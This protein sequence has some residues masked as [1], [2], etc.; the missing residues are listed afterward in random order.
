VTTIGLAGW[1][2]SLPKQ[3]RDYHEIAQLSGIP[4]E[5]IRDKFGIHQVY[6]AG[7]DEHASTL[8][9]SAAQN[10]LAMAGL[11]P[12]DVN[13]IIYHGSE[14]KDHIVWSVATKIQHLL[15]AERATAFEVYSL[16][17]GAGVAL[18]IARGMMTTDPR[19]KN[20]LLVTASREID[21]LDYRNER[22]R[23]MI[24]FSAGGGA[25]LLRRE[26]PQNRLVGTSVLTD[27]S[28]ADMVI[29]PAGG[30]RV[31]ASAQTLTR[32]HVLM[33]RMFPDARPAGGSL[34]AQLHPRDS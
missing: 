31:P 23:F 10:A 32:Q 2:I 14:F 8:G 9:A 20:V 13:L 28:L 18:N 19:L 21:L 34:A 33:Y 6:V 24:N 22:A 17:A 12:A 26:H 29:M 11:T 7:E 27:P 25:L 15:G 16:C 4:E 1:G 5:V 3:T 30:S